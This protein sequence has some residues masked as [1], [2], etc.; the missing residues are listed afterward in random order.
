MDFFHDSNLDCNN[1]ESSKE[2]VC[3]ECDIVSNFL[4]LDIIVG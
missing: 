3:D 1:R 2:I 4:S